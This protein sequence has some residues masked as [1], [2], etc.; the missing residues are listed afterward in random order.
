MCLK[1]P[2]SFRADEVSA[3]VFET[4]GRF[5]DAAAKLRLEA[6]RYADALC[7]RS[8]PLNCGRAAKPHTTA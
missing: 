7:C 1:A 3:T 6:K 4:Q 5:T 2:R 8:A